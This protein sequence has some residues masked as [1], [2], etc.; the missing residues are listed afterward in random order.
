MGDYEG[1]IKSLQQSIPLQRELVD[2]GLL[3]GNRIAAKKINLSIHLRSLASAYL[4]SNRNAEAR[5]QLDEAIKLLT[6]LSKQNLSPSF[7]RFV[8]VGLAKAL[9]DRWLALWA[10]GQAPDE[11][12][13]RQA[14]AL[15]Q[16][17]EHPEVP[18]LLGRLHQTDEALS[19]VKEIAADHTGELMRWS[20]IYAAC[21][22]AEKQQT[23]SHPDSPRYKASR[24]KAL[25]LLTTLMENGTNRDYIVDSPEFQ[26]LWDD[27]VCKSA[28]SVPK[29]PE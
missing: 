17:H 3:T 6:D 5:T 22:W 4:W 18:I 24:D 14:L 12:A 20:R 28:V 19:D 13:L 21:A 10:L 1:S 16:K 7:H 23:V 27:P 8:D 26:F 29:G 15:L 11:V 2:E 9:H 25:E